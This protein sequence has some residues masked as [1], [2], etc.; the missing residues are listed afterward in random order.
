V[1]FLIGLLNALLVLTSIFLICLVLIQR[2]K[3][4]GL[5]G[6]FG[7]PGGSSAF[8]TKAGDVFTRITIVTAGIWFALAM[9]LVLL[10]NRGG[11]SSA[12]QGGPAPSFNEVPLPGADMGAAATDADMNVP[13]GAGAAEVP[14]ALEPPKTPE[15]EKA[16]PAAGTRES[17][18]EPDQ[19]GLPPALTPEPSAPSRSEP[20]QS[21]ET[22]K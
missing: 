22:K 19:S 8:G 9:M 1:D 11:P 21:P 7:G 13:R 17:G 12:F 20:P 10:I 15:A 2:G 6:A 14:P 16:G 4:G 18:P 5:A 3:G